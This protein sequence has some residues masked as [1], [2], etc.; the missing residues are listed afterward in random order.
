MLD[1]LFFIGDALGV[2]LLLASAYLA[3]AEAID[4]TQ[5]ADGDQR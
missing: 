4:S 1:I 3:I 2:L 5:R